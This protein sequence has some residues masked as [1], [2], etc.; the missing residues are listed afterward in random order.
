MKYFKE[1]ETIASKDHHRF[2]TWFTDWRGVFANETQALKIFKAAQPENVKA[3][4]P[5]N[6]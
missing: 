1:T 2:Q 6:Q 5:A 4:S 3:D